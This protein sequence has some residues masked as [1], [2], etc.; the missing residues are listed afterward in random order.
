VVDDYNFVAVLTSGVSVENSFAMDQLAKHKA[1]TGAVHSTHVH[2][3]GCSVC[4][5]WMLDYAIFHHVPSNQY[6][7]TGMDC[8]AHIE[9]GHEAAFKRVAQS[10]RIAGKRSAAVAKA[11][12]YL[13]ALGLAEKAEMLFHE[14]EIG[15]AVVGYNIDQTAQEATQL[16]MTVMGLG[17]IKLNKA[18]TAKVLTAYWTL[19][20]MLRKL[21]KYNNW[22]DKV[23]AFATTLFNTPTTIIQWANDRAEAEKDM[24][25]APEG[26]QTVTGLI[27][28]TKTVES[29]FGYTP[30]YTLK[31]LVLSDLNFKVWAT[32]PANVQGEVEKGKRITFTATLTRS[33]TDET[34]AI[35]KRP[36]K[37]VVSN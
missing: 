16:I 14:N 10:R 30:T 18:E 35:A 27:L 37:A 24:I 11:F 2:G 17:D 20:D 6:I 5:A 12:D 13:D 28:S 7:R 22:S 34:F 29:N 9:A 21:V 36:S 19:V 33:E 8:A 23:A 26:K 31:M 4:G 32:V 25:A 15:G 1:A 3:G